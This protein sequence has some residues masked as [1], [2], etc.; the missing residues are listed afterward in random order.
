MCSS[1]DSSCKHEAGGCI[2]GSVLKL[3]GSVCHVQGVP[4]DTTEGQERPACSQM[5]A[6]RTLS[7]HAATSASSDYF[8][9]S[10]QESLQQI[11][12]AGSP[13]T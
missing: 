7:H 4:T 2:D 11:A 9:P 6:A 5:D 1:Q 12:I 8:Q 10:T 13:F 3:A